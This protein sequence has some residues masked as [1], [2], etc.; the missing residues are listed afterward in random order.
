MA[1]RSDKPAATAALRSDKGSDDR[2]RPQRRP[3][4]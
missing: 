3:P 1:R 4:L 2:F